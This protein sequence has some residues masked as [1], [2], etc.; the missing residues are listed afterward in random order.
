MGRVLR[1]PSPTKAAPACSCEAIAARFEHQLQ[2]MARELEMTLILNETGSKLQECLKEAGALMT[3]ARLVLE[4]A[5][6]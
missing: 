3:E 4:L 6:K 5:R 2:A 1:F